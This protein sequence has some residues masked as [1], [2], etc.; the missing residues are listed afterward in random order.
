VADSTL[1]R[2]GARAFTQEYLSKRVVSTLASMLPLI[3]FLLGRDGNKK[4]FEN[5]GVPSTGSLITGLQSNRPREEEIFGSEAYMPFQHSTLSA[6]GDGKAMGM[7]DT[8][9]TITGATANSQDQHFKRPRYAWFER[10]DPILVYN[11]PMRRAKRLARSNAER[12]QRVQSLIQ[13]ATDDTLIVHLQALCYELY[14][15]RSTYTVGQ[16]ATGTGPTDQDAEVWDHLLSLRN[17]AQTDNVCGGVDRSVSGNEF[18]QG[19]LVT[20]HRAPNLEDLINEAN[21]TLGCADIGQ[22]VT[23][24]LCGPSLFP[25]FVSQV[26]GRGGVVT[27]GGLPEMGEF[28]Y[29]RPILRFNNTWVTYDPNI[30]DKARVHP[31]TAATKFAKNAVSCLNLD[32]WTVAF[33]PEAKFTVDKPFNL[34]QTDGGKDAMKSQIRTELIVCNE[35]PKANVWFDDVG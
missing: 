15:L 11:K 31:L 13:L 17:F 7:R 29:K 19:K 25:T 1:I 10:A 9:P 18:H 35:A 14:G 24:M 28:G 4:G 12:E 21:Y 6:Q 2:S 27:Y 34:A 22:G 20:D 5:I 30:P 16:G 8:L 32:T 33:D 23:L 3:Y 26:Q